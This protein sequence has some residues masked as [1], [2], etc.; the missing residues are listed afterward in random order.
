MSLT[1]K[2][3]AFAV[4]LRTGRIVDK[5]VNAGKMREPMPELPITTKEKDGGNHRTPEQ[6]QKYFKKFYEFGLT[7]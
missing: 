3:E 2:Q 4:G 7:L 6:M 1:S 5:F